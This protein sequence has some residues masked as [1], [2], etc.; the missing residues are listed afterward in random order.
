MI[1]L[2][3]TGKGIMFIAG[4]LDTNVTVLEFSG[5]CLLVL[6]AK[7]YWIQGKAYQRTVKC[8]IQSYKISLFF[9]FFFLVKF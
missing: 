2:G 9:L 1:K 6:I 5:R 8:A 7:M 4:K 3:Q